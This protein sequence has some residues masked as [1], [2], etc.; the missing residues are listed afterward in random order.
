M[1]SLTATLQDLQKHHYMDI[2]SVVLLR[3]G[4]PQLSRL[5]RGDGTLDACNAEFEPTVLEIRK[6]THM[7]PNMQ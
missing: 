7:P 6:C 5:A 4:C 1:E 3:L 2:L